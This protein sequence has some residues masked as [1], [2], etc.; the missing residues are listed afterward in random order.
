[1]SGAERFGVEA[2]EL[3]G[4]CGCVQAAVCLGT[5]ARS[6]PKAKSLIPAINNNLLVIVFAQLI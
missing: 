1:M 5:F 4:V 6:L 2:D 3:N